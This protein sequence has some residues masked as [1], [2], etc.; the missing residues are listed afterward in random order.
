M[1]NEL[2]LDQLQAVN[3]A[4]SQ[5][6]WNR[7]KL[8]NAKGGYNIKQLANSGQLVPKMK[9]IPDPMYRFIPGDMY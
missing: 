1:T 6:H 3:G 9:Y 5:T 7:N 4:D 2:T 8:R